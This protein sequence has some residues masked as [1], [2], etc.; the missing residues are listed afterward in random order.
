MNNINSVITRFRAYQLGTAGSSFS[1]FAKDHF[2]LIE[3]MITE[4][5]EPQLKAELVECGKNSIDTLHIT[6]WDRDHCSPDGLEWILNE[7]RPTRVEMP[8]YEPHTDSGET[9]R[10]QIERYQATRNKIDSAVVIQAITPTYIDTLNNASELLYKNIYYHPRALREDSNDNS[11]IKLF[12]SGCFNVLSLGDVED[13]SIAA[14]LKRCKTILCAELDVMIL[15]HHGADNGFTT[16]NLLRKLS[17][18]VAIC[19]S[20]YDNQFDHP[21]QEI[22]SMLYEQNIP[23]FTTK[24]GDVLIASIGGHTMDYKVINYCANSTKISSERTFRS[25]KSKLL[26]SN[27]DT[28][29]NVLA[30][31]NNWPH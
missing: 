9:C 25:R 5:N 29:R 11:T 2:T 6:S 7:L 27:A 17:P 22:R 28:I 23:L 24:T 31:K 20:N 15:A 30:K 14:S 18:S 1:Y 10:V 19:S 16:K 4:V 12:R 21:R 3:A 26:C 8:G 13:P